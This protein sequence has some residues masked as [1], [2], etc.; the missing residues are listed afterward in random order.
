M[1]RTLYDDLGVS[2]TA[3]KQEIS[4]A[5]K[6]LA[7]KYHPDLQT[8]EKAKLKAEKEMIKINIAYE[9]LK[10]EEKRRNYDNQLIAEEEAERIA[11]ERARQ[12]AINRRYNN[13]ANINNYNNNNVYNNG[14]YYDNQNNDNYTV[15]ITYEYVN[16]IQRINAE[17][18][19][20]ILLIV[21]ILDVIIG[22]VWLI[23][24]TRNM[25]ISFYENNILFRFIS[26]FIYAILSSI[27]STFE[28]FKE[29]IKKG[30]I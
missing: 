4:K 9:T 13:N 2:K 7:K 28:F 22:V 10:D 11:K 17:R 21:G 20:R 25:L 8:N 26:K 30:Y 15:H 18:L 23:P 3:T 1:K 29:S 19:L 24:A 16:P 14:H 5:Y 27:M 12:E 6:I